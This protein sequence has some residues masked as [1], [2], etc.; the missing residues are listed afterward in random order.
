MEDSI[1]RWKDIAS[2]SFTNGFGALLGYAVVLVNSV[3]VGHAAVE[4]Q[5]QVAMLAGF[6]LA[7]AIQ[8]VLHIG[9]ALGLVSAF[10]TLVSQA[11]GAEDRTRCTVYLGQGRAVLT[12]HWILIFPIVWYSDRILR[13]IGI[14]S[15]VARHAG[16]FNR[17][18]VVGWFFRSQMYVSRRFLSNVNRPRPN[19]WATAISL[20]LHILLVL[21]I[22]ARTIGLERLGIVCVVTIFAHSS[23]LVGYLL[24]NAENLGLQTRQRLN[25]FV[26]FRDLAGFVRVAFLGLVQVCAE[27]WALEVFTIM[28]SWLDTASLAAC[29]VSYNVTSMGFL[30]GLGISL[31]ASGLVGE[32]VG[33]GNVTAARRTSF[34]CGVFTIVV[35]LPAACALLVGAR[36]LAAAF[37]TEL[38]VQERLVPLLRLYA[39]TMLPDYLN[40]VVAGLLRALGRP[41]PAAVAYPLVYYFLMLPLAYLLAFILDFGVLGMYF[42]YAAVSI[43]LLGILALAL[44]RTSVDT[45]VADCRRRLVV[46][47]REPEDAQAVEMNG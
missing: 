7:M 1:P 11:N 10:D 14:D 27:F 41:G 12:L 13:S 33:K 40:L 45:A 30:A 34:R 23:V 22:G 47:G 39:F 3:V 29:T 25:T 26:V 2:K 31:A 5:E 42:A 18:N 15:H 35:W 38:D 46:E 32:A 37:S 24:Y 9:P 28:S 20:L 21:C 8:N 36:G 44:A 19:L 43:L 4:R 17:I 6:G 16:A